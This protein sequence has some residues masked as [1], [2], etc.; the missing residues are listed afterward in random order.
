M[1]N[2]SE[3]E[4]V[5]A[6]TLETSVIQTCLYNHTLSALNQQNT[7][8]GVVYKNEQK[9]AVFMMREASLFG[10]AIHGVMIDRA[11]VW[12]PGYGSAADFE[13]FV[14]AL[15]D[16]LPARLGRRRRFMPEVE[17]SHAV[18]KVLARHGWRHRKGSEYQTIWL[19]LCSPEGDLRAN[20]RKNWRGSLRKA[21]K[22]DMTIEWDDRGKLLPWLINL[23]HKD[24]LAREYDGPDTKTLYALGRN[25]AVEGQCLIGR[26]SQDKQALATV[27]FLKHGRSATYQMGW[28]SENGRDLGAGYR[29]LWDGALRLKA[30]GTDV[31]DLGGVNDQSAA[32]IKKFK[33]G[34]G[35]RLV[36]LPGLYY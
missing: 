2:I 24:K 16:E 21:E 29:L 27:M 36:T 5:F 11:P 14:Q 32:G 30:D 17:D 26:A 33:E 12:L 34:L 1:L 35:G 9:V 31:L 28:V 25:F 4:Q 6:K 20:L 22:Q 10:Q 8:I 7:R 18:R 15:A 13:G 19:E 3:W 23:Y